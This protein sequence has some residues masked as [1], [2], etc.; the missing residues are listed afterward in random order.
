MSKTI[1]YIGNKLSKHGNTLTAIETLG[2]FLE[3]H[4]YKVYYASS[5]KNKIVRMLDMMVTTLKIYRKYDYVFI[6]TYSTYNFWYAFIISQMCRVLGLK[7]LP[8]LHGGDL[9]RRL[10]NNPFLCDLIFKNAYKICVPS[11]YLFNA[12]SEKYPR[13]IV[14]I[15]NTIELKHYAFLK[16]NV[17]EPKLL[18]VRSFSEIYNPKMAIQVFFEIK[19]VFPNSELCMVGPDKEN[20]IE[21][22][23]NFAQELGVNVQFTGKLEK[24]EWIE[25]SKE[26]DIFL[27]TTHFDNMP[28]SVMEAMA[29][30]LVVVST[31]VGG[32]PFLVKKDYN[33]I[34]VDDNDVEAMVTSIKNLCTNKDLFYELSLNARKY[35]EKYDIDVIK[36]QWFD[37]LK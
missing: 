28:V 11:D 37:I 22:C 9:P 4:G 13:N 1:L 19:K 30:G 31:N 7:Y 18:W 25:L 35:V 23:M 32:I 17:L 20:I 2:S 14:Y 15:P 16:R 24:E 10:E 21:E 8:K 3:E 36:S 5:C 33:G 27:N 26:Y 34:L 29:L 6:D 12:F